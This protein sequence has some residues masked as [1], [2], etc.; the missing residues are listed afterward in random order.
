MGGGILSDLLKE[1][2]LD[3]EQVGG[4]L[5]VLSE[6]DNPQ[7]G[8]LVMLR[9][10]CSKHHHVEGQKMVPVQAEARWKFNPCCGSVDLYNTT[11]RLDSVR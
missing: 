7:R 11:A 10:P 1:V 6:A 4:A 2:Q 5:N 3:V 9:I 8:Y